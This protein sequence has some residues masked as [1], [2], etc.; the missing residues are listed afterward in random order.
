M[1]KTLSQD[2]DD[3]EKSTNSNDDNY[4]NDDLIS[5][6][7][8]SKLINLYYSHLTKYSK[9]IRDKYL[10]N[11]VIEQ[12]P[13]EIR[14]FQEEFQLSLESVY[15][16][17][18]ILQENANIKENLILQ[19]NQ[20]A[21]LLKISKY[22]EI[23][24]LYKVTKDYIKSH[25]SD[26]DF[27]IQIIQHEIDKFK[28]TGKTE[29]EINS[30]IE[31]ILSTQIKQSLSNEKFADL[32]ISIIYRIVEKSSFIGL[33]SDDL[34]DFIK[35][36]VKKFYVLFQFVDVK[37]LSENR[38]I[39]ILDLYENMD[40]DG[41]QYFN[42]LPFNF[43][44]FKEMMG[45][46]TDLEERL[47][48]QQSKMCEFEEQ[49]KLLQKQFSDSEA[50]QR[51]KIDE[52][53]LTIKNLQKQ[54]DDSR[55]ANEQLQNQLK[56]SEDEKCQITQKLADSEKEKQEIQEKMKE[57]LLSVQGE[58]SASVKG[59]VV[60]ARILLILKGGSLD[61]S[62]SKYIIS[63]IDAKTIGANAYVKGEAITSLEMDTIDFICKPGAYFVRCIVFDTDGRSAE[64]VSNKVTT[65]GTSVLLGYNGRK[66][67]EFSLYR[68]KYK[69][70]VWGAK[71]GDSVGTRATDAK[72]NSNG[73]GGLGGYS[74]G[75][76]QLNESE[77]IYVFV[78]GAGGPGDSRD[79][80]EAIGGYP[81]GGG[82]KTGHRR[83]ATCVPGTGGG[84][85]SIRVS[86]SSDYHRVI[87]AGGG[88][89]ASGNSLK[90]SSGGFGGGTR[91]GFCHYD[92]RWLEQGAGTQ[93]GS[94]CGI[95]CNNKGDPG[96]FGKGATGKYCQG[97]DSGGGGG[98]GWYGGGS[99]GYGDCWDCSSGGG[100][101]G[102]I[103]TSDSFS[104]WRSGDP[105]KASNFL[106]GSSFYLSDAQTFAGN[107]EFPRPDGNGTEQGH[108]GN[109]YAKITPQ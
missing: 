69:L 60:S 2:T 93:T 32:P 34:F 87:V 97:R 88:G 16:F 31:D 42:Y 101:S 66:P 13:Q 40:K 104:A 70:E 36:S 65:S 4:E 58:I 33:S 44:I 63:A 96:D 11:D 80:E 103:F 84:S 68:G 18:Q 37:K 79:G 89:G 81:D 95:G 78:G 85:T 61:V 56:T 62:R 98:G 46:K 39:E 9:R 57:E 67:A 90:T 23:R 59:L 82:T 106:L 86:K 54:L 53:E 35:K 76:L 14:Q 24:K 74:R 27:S 49:V 75:T 99:G 29:Y 72:S 20:C 108:S 64:F 15:S 52:F 8:G 10:F 1:N 107:N 51:S 5:F 12:F 38:L 77:K 30:E 3:L 41:Q 94:T 43:S 83:S 28:E 92:G 91:G 102:W 25:T 50:T 105:S 48:S 22:L 109:G 17:F 100:G 47:E 26:V 71:G 73:Q 6:Q 45:K 19:Y 55:Q 21:D 7:L